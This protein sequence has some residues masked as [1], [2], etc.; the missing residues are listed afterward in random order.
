[1]PTTERRSC[2]A[3]LVIT[4]VACGAPAEDWSLLF[5][6]LKPPWYFD[7]DTVGPRRGLPFSDDPADYVPRCSGCHTYEDGFRNITPGWVLD[8][9]GITRGRYPFDLASTCDEMEVR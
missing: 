7:F 3:I 5:T 4:F 1:M 2:A 9:L 8:R 6:D